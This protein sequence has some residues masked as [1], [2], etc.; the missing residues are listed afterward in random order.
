M[1]QQVEIPSYIGFDASI[2][3]LVHWLQESLAPLSYKS[4]KE[5]VNIYIERKA[6]ISLFFGNTN[7]LFDFTLDNKVTLSF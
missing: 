4:K 6:V 3:G 1:L 5:A 2:T 7:K